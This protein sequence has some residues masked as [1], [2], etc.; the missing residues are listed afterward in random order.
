MI[1]SLCVSYK[2]EVRVREE[3]KDEMV[4]ESKRSRLPLLNLSPG[5]KIALKML[6]SP[7]AASESE[8][9]DIAQQKDHDLI[10]G[11]RLIYYLLLLRRAGFLE[12]SLKS[13]SKVLATVEYL[14]D[15][16]IPPKTI[17][18]NKRLVFSRFA[19]VCKRDDQAVLES[20][21]CQ[22]RIVVKDAECLDAIFLLMRPGS[23][24]EL[25]AGKRSRLREELQP[26][27]QLLH[28]LSFVLGV[29][30]EEEDRFRCW[31]FHDLIF[32][33]RAR[34]WRRGPVGGT[35]RFGCKP[36]PVP[37]TDAPTSIESIKL[38][39]PNLESLILNDRPFTEVLERRK[40]LR[41][42]SGRVI[43]VDQLGEFLYRVARVRWPKSL[44]G[45]GEASSL[46]DRPYPNAGARYEL[47]LY[48]LVERCKGLSA[49]LYHYR[50]D[51][52][53]L[54]RLRGGT[55]YLQQ[56]IQDAERGAPGR[57]PRS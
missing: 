45:K 3:N 17:L 54:S 50:P 29:E 15:R 44:A 36:R 38:Y 25:F 21:L 26:F 16:P 47:E 31:E 7:G 11:C 51:S 32:H 24:Q 34:D 10:S 20:P 12:Y 33:T 1:E 27:V 5:L 18:T 13:R 41:G 22:A 57:L 30:E 14:D 19:Y 40:S 39:R 4:L 8:L 52:H 43:S 35:F 46:I 42:D 23:L 37:A 56:M 6:M 49:G 48:T 2:P 55:A 28:A 9:Y 53:E